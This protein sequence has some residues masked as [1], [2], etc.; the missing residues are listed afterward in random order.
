MQPARPVLVA[1]SI[2][3]T[4]SDAA[5]EATDGDGRD[6]DE[7][8]V[9]IF[10]EQIAG[11]KAGGV[12][13]VW[14]ETMVSAKEARAA[15][16]AAISEGLSYVATASFGANGLTP[17]GL[18][19]DGFAAAFDGLPVEPVAIGANCCEGPQSALASATAMS[20]GRKVML[21]VKANCG[22]PTA[23]DGRMLHPH[24]PEIM[25]AHALA[26]IDA[27][28]HL[29][30]GCCGATADHVAAMREAIDHRQIMQGR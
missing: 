17:S 19:P 14:L 5:S 6:A 30:G 18:A 22:L 27:G 29:I 13:L 1:G 23:I 3:P 28:V 20:S 7:E 24:G 12:D 9:S 2:G 8:L 15:A 25:A 26:A 4:W 21:A 16:K 11:L 10:A